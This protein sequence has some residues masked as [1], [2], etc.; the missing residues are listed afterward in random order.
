MLEA[1]FANFFWE[2]CSVSIFENFKAFFARFVQLF[3]DIFALVCNFTFSH[4]TRIS[5]LL[6]LC[7]GQVNYDVN[8]LKCHCD[9][10]YYY[11]WIII[12]SKG[13]WF[14]GAFV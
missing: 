3:L 6:K 14:K 7:K 5:R 13:N 11:K 12:S 8:V 9:L 10:G 2:S 4:F 1:F